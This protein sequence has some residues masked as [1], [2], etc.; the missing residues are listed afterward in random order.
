MFIKAS[1]QL[2]GTGP[3]KQLLLQNSTS[4][5]AP[6]ETRTLWG[7]ASRETLRN[8]NLSCARLIP[9]SAA[10]GR[11]EIQRG[12][13]D[14]RPELKSS[15]DCLLFLSVPL[16]SASCKTTT[17]TGRSNLQT[18]SQFIKPRLHSRGVISFF[19]ML[20]IVLTIQVHT[21]QHNTWKEEV[22]LAA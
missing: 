14:V 7:R 5:L 11:E 12:Q 13:R 17:S 22:P 19:N 20:L 15:N 6:V 1:H 2:P 8:D 16:E 21:L 3:L 10:G 18:N 4:S 9:E